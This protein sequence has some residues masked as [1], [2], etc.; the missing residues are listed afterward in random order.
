MSGPTPFQ[1]IGPFFH[2]ALACAPLERAAAERPRLSVRGCVRDGAGAPV[3]DA[4]LEFWHE[5]AGFARVA[6]DAAGAFA[7][8][9]VLPAAEDAEAPHFVVQLF[10]RGILTRLL[11]RVY[12]EGQPANAT[13]PVLGLVPEIRRATLIARRTASDAYC[14]DIALQG[15]DETVFLDA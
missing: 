1:T 12:F 15:P 13:D 11:T 6:T 5:D 10:A 7:F 2:G 3:P 8:D 14:F 9:T 4:L